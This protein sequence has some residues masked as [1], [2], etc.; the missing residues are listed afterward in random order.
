MK[1]TKE[2]RAAKKAAKVEADRIKKSQELLL[3]EKI[4]QERKNT[5]EPS[6]IY[7]IGERV[8]YGMWDW[9][10]ILQSYKGSKYYKVFSVNRGTNRNIPDSTY[11]K[12][13]YISWYDLT[14]Y[15]ED[16]S[17]VETLTQDDD[18]HFT[19]QQRDV[20]AI[21]SNYFNEY[22]IDLEPEYQRGNVWTLEQKQSLIESIFHNVDIGKIAIIKR[23]WGSNPNTPLTPKLYEMLDGKQ[24]LTA[25]VEFFTG[26]FSF[27]GKYY[28]DLH[29]ADKHHFKYYSIS[30]AETEPL[31]KKQKYR[32]FLKLNTTGTPVDP[33][34]MEKVLNML[35]EEIKNN[36]S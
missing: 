4:R 6:I 15:R 27:K 32:Y 29:P 33:A 30:Y 24:R 26:Q 11:G 14:P 8:R 28:N 22:G 36:E 23:P 19:F 17:D 34:H 25:L 5:P 9:T 3:S 18:I 1:M 21:L 7:N 31:T 2:E 35:N 16:W 13:H 10:C 20:N 12:I